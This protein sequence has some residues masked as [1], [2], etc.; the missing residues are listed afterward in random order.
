MKRRTTIYNGNFF[1][2]NDSVSYR[3]KDLDQVID[4]LNGKGIPV[5]TGTLYQ[6]LVRLKKNTKNGKKPYVKTSKDNS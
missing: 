3:K 6:G 1:L 2:E 5:C 4:E